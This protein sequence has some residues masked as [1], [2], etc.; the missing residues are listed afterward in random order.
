MGA[1]YVV[2][3]YG[4]DRGGNRA[5]YAAFDTVVRERDLS[6]SWERGD[7]VGRTALLNAVAAQQDADRA[8][9]VEASALAA[10]LELAGNLEALALTVV[11][12]EAA[13]EARESI[14]ADAERAIT[15]LGA[16]QAGP[17][18]HEVDMLCGVADIKLRELVGMA[19][20]WR[21]EVMAQIAAHPEEWHTPHALDGPNASL[22]R[23]RIF[24]DAAR[25]VTGKNATG[26]AR[27]FALAVYVGDDAAARLGEA[28]AVLGGD[29]HSPASDFEAFMPYRVYVNRRVYE[30]HVAPHVALS[31]ARKLGWDM[32]RR[33]R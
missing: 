22:V 25:P 30:P 32:E 10:A 14:Q 8:S 16:T 3:K 4:T 20:F 1:R 26:V 7:I 9:G 17:Y 31:E 21:D 19:A 28:I 5:E 13:R 2:R 11:A 29:Q 33:K 18:L 15:D 12:R 24:T 27:D 23:F 6:D